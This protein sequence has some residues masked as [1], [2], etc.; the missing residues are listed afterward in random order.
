[1]F[2]FT[3]EINSLTFHRNK[4]N[5]YKEDLIILMGWIRPIQ[6]F[7]NVYRVYKPQL[8][9]ISQCLEHFLSLSIQKKLKK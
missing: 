9:F 5:S 4:S 2:H 7:K 1:M 3:N 6:L 8:C